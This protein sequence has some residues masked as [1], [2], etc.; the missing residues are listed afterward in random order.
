MTAKEMQRLSAKK[1]WSKLTSAERSKVMARVRAGEKMTPSPVLG[2][3][4][5]KKE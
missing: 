1:R 2:G 3:N 5:Q 4:E